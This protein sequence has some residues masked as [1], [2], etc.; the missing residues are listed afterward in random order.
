MLYSVVFILCSCHSAVFV[1][2]SAVFGG[3]HAVLF[4]LCLSVLI[5]CVC[6]VKLCKFYV[7][8]VFNC[9]N[10]VCMLC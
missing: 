1:L 2:R 8:S 9:V 6:C 4:M 3:V 7:H 5:P 10:S